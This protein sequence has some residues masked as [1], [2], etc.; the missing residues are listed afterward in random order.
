MQPI[1]SIPPKRGNA[2]AWEKLLA[3]LHYACLCVRLWEGSRGGGG[4]V[5]ISELDATIDIPQ[6]RKGG[7]GRGDDWVMDVS[8]LPFKKWGEDCGHL[9]SV[10]GVVEGVTSRLYTRLGV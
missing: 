5:D 8:V 10:L 6:G 3:T 4:G 2:C 1:Q 7:Q 9:M